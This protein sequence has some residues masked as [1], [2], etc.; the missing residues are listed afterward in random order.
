[1][2]SQGS[3][4]NPPLGSAPTLL[5]T[6]PSGLFDSGSARLGHAT[7]ATSSSARSLRPAVFLDRDGVINR[8]RRGYVKSWAEF[9]F[10]PGVFGALRWLADTSVAVVTV[11][12]QSAVGRGLLSMEGMVDIHRRMVEGIRQRGG[13]IDA[14]SYC[15]HSPLDGCGCRKPLPGQLIIAADRMGLDLSRSYFV[16]DAQTD[17]LAAVAAGSSPVL[18]LTGRGRRQREAMPPDLLALCHVAEGL[19][20]AVEWILA[21]ASR[22]KPQSV[23]RSG[24]RMET[25]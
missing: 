16:G 25:C 2:K 7:A 6:H 24:R 22:G 23:P 11:S 19:M 3:V 10:L 17:M 20:E 12:N 15:P 14:G 8:N 5:I 9:E 1:M 18:V 4:S 21:D 13:R